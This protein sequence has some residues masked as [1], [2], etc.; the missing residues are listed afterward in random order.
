M[1]V[2]IV[3][4][5]GD[6]FRNAAVL[7]GPDGTRLDRYEKEHRVPFGEY[8]PARHLLE[9]V[10]DAAR[11]VPRD[12]IPGEG[13]ALLSAPVGPLGVVIS[14]EVFCAD[15]V[16]EAVTSG[17]KVVLLPT[18]A[19]SYRTPEVPALDVAAARLRALEFDRA[20]LQAAP[21][22]HSPVILPNGAVAAQSMLGA[23]TLLREQ[24]PFSNGPDPLRPYRRRSDSHPRSGTHRRGAVEKS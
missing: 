6:R 1:I 18:N 9:R 24:R 17:G 21:T 11:L 15:R 20:V 12:A 2:G 10:T 4:S 23:A 19:A 22:G 7:W 16:R 3:E 13:Q 5:S 8:L 14:Y